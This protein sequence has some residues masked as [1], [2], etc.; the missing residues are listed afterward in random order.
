M[1]HF[2]PFSMT[3][4][5]GVDQ[6][7]SW[8]QLPVQLYLAKPIGEY[9]HQNVIVVHYTVSILNK[10]SLLR[11]LKFVLTVDSVESRLSRG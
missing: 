6:R 8:R 7:I 2:E 5:V 1:K 10:V 4:D 9:D 3:L 11:A